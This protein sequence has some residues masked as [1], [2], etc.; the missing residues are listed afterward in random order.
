MADNVTPIRFW[1]RQK[2]KDAR[3]KLATASKTNKRHST[4]TGM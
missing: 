4:M 1:L 2:I 3:E